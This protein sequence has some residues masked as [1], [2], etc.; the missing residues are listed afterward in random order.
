VG[1]LVNDEM[2]IQK[3]DLMEFYEDFIKETE[4]RFNTLQLIKIITPIA[5]LLFLKGL[6]DEFE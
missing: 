4:H 6:S 5:R 3:V 1:K 2:F